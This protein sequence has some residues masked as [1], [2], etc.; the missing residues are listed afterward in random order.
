MSK[1]SL[2]IKQLFDSAFKLYQNGDFKKSEIIL[3]KNLD[4]F[5]DHLPSIFLLG[6]LSA[7]NKE[8]ET[9]KK[10]L[11]QAIKLKPDFI[12]GHNNLGNVFQELDEYQD[13]ITCYQSAIKLNPKYAEA[14]YNLGKVYKELGNNREA[15]SCYENAIK[16]EP[17]NPKF[18]YHLAWIKK[19]L[20]NYYSAIDNYKKALSISNDYASAK[21]NLA[22]L[23]LSTENFSEG[24][25]DYEMRHD[26]DKVPQRVKNI[27]KLKQWDG[28]PLDG[29]L[30]VHGE[31]GVGD[32]IIHSSIIAD[33]RKI[34]PDIC[35]T[36]DERMLSLFQ[37]SFKD[38]DVRG[39]N[40]NLNYADND[41]HIPLASL[42]SFLR[43]SIDDFPKQPEAYIVPDP[44]KVEHFKHALSQH[45]K[46]K[47]GLSWHT[48]GDRDSDR[49]ISLNQMA[50]LLTLPD[51]E[52][53]NLQ[54]G[55][56]AEE[57]EKFKADHGIEI[58]N[59]DDLDLMNDFEGLAALMANC[60]LI[61][62]ISNI[63]AHIA[64]AIGKKTI[65]VV[66]IYTQWHWFYERNDSLWY[67]NVELF[68]QQQY[69]KWEEVIDKIYHE[70]KNIGIK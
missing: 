19:D 29:T 68:R 49:T 2:S 63:T 32:L 6:T 21:Y 23:N 3:K 12:E 66:P 56:T 35:L 8:F 46:I 52:F 38:I 55:D 67:P 20:G 54:Y 36:V 24:W 5:P 40:S 44:E 58:F 30:F 37:R 60:D 10:L 53:V 26:S 50:Q 13:A 42:G 25:R 33:L 1:E 41:R 61:I 7:Q 9:A 51:V 57:R 48:I 17:N 18:Y 31:Q 11:Q 27:L 4:S 65:V 15:I 69:G 62:T 28:K 47:I 39:Y 70:I 22:R 45:K 14:H 64:G 59:M 16:F 43:T 34:Q